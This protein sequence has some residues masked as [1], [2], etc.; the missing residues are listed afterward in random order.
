MALIAVDVTPMRPGGENGGVKVLTLELLRAFQ[1]AAPEDRFLL[2]TASWNHR[3]LATLEAPNMQR[4]QVLDRPSPRLPVLERFRGRLGRILRKLVAVATWSAVKRMA[5]M[6]RPLASRG[7]DLLFCPF[8]ALNYFE[9]GIPAVSV[10]HDMQHKEYPQF[11]PEEEIVTR[12]I[13]MADVRA[14]ASRII[15]ISEHVRDSVL[16]HLDADP[17]RTHVVY[18]CIQSRL[19]AQISLDTREAEA[20]RLGIHMRPYMVY[21]ANFWPHKN[22]RMLLTAYGIFRHRCP[23]PS[24]D[25]V[26]TGALEEEERFLEEATQRMGIREHVHFLGFLPQEVLDGVLQGAQFL[27]FPSLYEG[28][29]IPVV[30]AMSLGKPVLCA[31][32]T[33]LPEIAGEAA[34]FFDPRKPEAMAAAMIRITGDPALVEDLANRGKRRA[35][36]FRTERMVEGYLGVFREALARP[37]S[38]DNGVVGVFEDGWTSE[39]VTI[40][41]GGGSAGRYLEV[42]IDAPLDLPGGRRR[43]SVMVDGR[44]VRRERMV[45]GETRR[46]LLPLPDRPGEVSLVVSPGFQPAE[47]GLGSDT[48]RLGLLCR[49][50]RV[51]SPDGENIS[52]LKGMSPS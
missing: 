37:S 28:F 20:R 11:F 10:I 29:G 36:E 34:L 40:T 43:L 23:K 15:C 31:N 32:V 4:L 18:N 35:A 48:R 44:T 24:T 42:L 47:C 5:S 46:I 1:Y 39:A 19:G 52:L 49:A 30:E 21:P 6:R 2:L 9:P 50:C 27:I 45:K 41:H 3:E 13:F 25:L 26:L 38:I 14:R 33:S 8:T 12:D 16:R 22:H 7:V 51:V 17:K